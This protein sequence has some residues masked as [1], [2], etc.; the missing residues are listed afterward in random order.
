MLGYNVF[1]MGH[2]KRMEI[3]VSKNFILGPPQLL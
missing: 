2:T 3:H 1:T